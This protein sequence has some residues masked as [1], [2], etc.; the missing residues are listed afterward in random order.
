MAR[1]P[2]VLPLLVAA[3]TLVVPAGAALAGG[4]CHAGATTGEGDTVEMV[5]A[6]FTPT[7]LHVDPGAKVTF[8]NRS[9]MVHN[10]TANGWGHFDDIDP[11]GAFT[12]TFADEGVYPYACTYHPGMS[13]AVVVGDGEG[14]ASGEAVTVAPFEPPAAPSPE[15]VVE[16]V[17]VTEPSV[18]GWWLGGAAGV[19]IGLALGL[20]VRRRTAQVRMAQAEPAGSR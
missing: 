16:T 3:F 8:V 5:D 14:A 4:G 19:A 1:R 7:T 6:C 10:V 15:V 2:F 9:A 18:T 20:A 17:R 11:D 12:A 13:G